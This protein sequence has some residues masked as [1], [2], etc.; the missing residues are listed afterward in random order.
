MILSKMSIKRP[1]L[2]TVITIALVILGIQAYFKMP[3]NLMPDATIP[4]VTVQVIYPG[5]G[6]E[7]IE[8]NITKKIEDEIVTVAGLDYVQSFVME[9]ATQIVCFFKMEKD[10]DIA[11]QEVKDK[12]D[13]IIS[14]F[15]KEAETP[16]IMK[17]DI[18]AEPVLFLSYTSSLNPGQAY[19]YADKQIKERLARIQGVSQVELK[20]GQER[21]IQIILDRHKLDKYLISPLQ[22]VEQLQT[23]NLVVPGGNVK[24]QGAE[25]SIKVDAEFKSLDDIRNLKITTPTGELK[26]GELASIQD[27]RKKAESLARFANLENKNEVDGST[28]ININIK[29]QSDANTVDVADRVKAE[30][31]KINES[32]PEGQKLQLATDNS[33]FVKDSVDD[34]LSAIWQG[35]LLTA[36]LLYLF[37]HNFRS[38]IIVAV[39]MP[40]TLIATLLLAKYSG[41]SLNMMS[42]MA[43]SV[44]VG[45]LVTNSVVILENIDRYIGMGMSKKEA[46]DKGT[47]EIAVAVIA[48]TVTNV[49]VFVPIATMESMVGQFFK[50]FGLTVTFVMLFS[51]L[52][53]F[54]ITPMLSALL[55]KD[56][57]KEK[58]DAIKKKGFGVWFD[59]G[60]DRMSLGYRN[61]LHSSI[62]TGGRRITMIVIS[63]VVLAISLV[64]IGPKLGGEFIPMV[65]QGDVEISVELPT[66]YSLDKTAETFTEIEKR[67]KVYPEVKTLI[68]TIGN[69][70]T[71][72]GSNLGY[73]KVKIKEEAISQTAK[74]V[75]ELSGKLSDIPG[76]NIK[77]AAINAM[78]QGDG[79]APIQFQVYGKDSKKLEVITRQVFDILKNTPGA[80]NTDTD[81]RSGK[82]EVIIVPNRQKMSDYGVSSYQLALTVRSAIEG[83]TASKYKQDG[84]E[85]DIRIKLQDEDIND[86]DKV[87]NLLI[88]TKYGNI[89]VADLA[90]VKYGSAPT[91]ITRKNKYR[92]NSVTASASGR[93]T[94][95]IVA[96]VN[97]AIK[98]KIQL[99]E[100]Y[101]IDVGGDAEMMEKS[102]KDFSQA[103]ILAIVLTFL[104]IAGL[105]ESFVQAV[106]IMFTVPLAFIGV[107]WSLL[108]AGESLNIFS[109]MAGVM[110]IGIVVNN[111]ILIQDYANQLMDLGQDKM[112]AM[113]ESCQV[114]LKAIIMATLASILGMLP[115]ALGLGSGAELRQ[116]M[117]I[118]SI[119]GLLVGGILAQFVIPALYVQFVK[120]KKVFDHDND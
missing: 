12:V 18:N 73:L 35:I 69:L 10:I 77:V 48:S 46:A 1:V 93:T 62:K 102:N 5:A 63:F 105:L 104:L 119:G 98:D 42:L 83:L 89:K 39:S 96:D 65:N 108:F 28:A 120:N 43:L 95:E 114:K 40:I 91:L 13:A 107:L 81:L 78:G 68:T 32:L 17:Y 87:K 82:P 57:S 44:S 20:G 56:L 66:Y 90:M 58:A 54:T 11:N 38:T 59:K 50:E 19:E 51:I 106:L 8:S 31:K 27:T 7:E 115:L 117:G 61:I 92:M 112:S 49:V 41:F 84:E 15:P 94:G 33:I 55:L 4:V 30:V 21:E 101:R 110:L 2:I 72:T 16:V 47:A 71:T 9:N 80:I 26:L 103:F 118:V 97:A 116:G 70:K 74:F 25:Y 85:Y 6:P 100:G 76:A 45:T 23:N 109:M 99:P 79:G 67:V 75:A 34:T 60:F 37:L 86:L 14:S 52:I 36:L 24:R 3:L 29:K 111:A 64:W 113:L 53:S 88:L 22:L